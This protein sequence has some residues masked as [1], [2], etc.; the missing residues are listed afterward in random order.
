MAKEKSGKIG[1]GFFFYF[2]FFLL[3]II[4]AMLIIF[5]VMMFMPGKS[6]MGL[7][8]FA[9]KGTEKVEA[10]TDTKTQ[11]DFE[12]P[13]FNSVEISADYTNVTIQKNNDYNQNGIYIVNNSKGFVASKKARDFKYEVTLQDGVLKINVTEPTGFLYFSND[14]RVVF[15]IC[16]ENI[17][18]LA[19]K[20]VKIKTNGSVNIGGPVKTGYSYDLALG[21]LYIEGD[22]GSVTMS[23]HAPKTFADLSIK[24][25]SGGI[26]FNA[27]EVWARNM[28]LQ[29][30]S[31]NIY[32][33]KLD[34]ESFIILNTHNGKIEIGQISSF[35]SQCTDA[36]MTISRVNGSADFG[37]SAQT[38]ASS[39][40]NIG[41]ITGNLTALQAQNTDFKIG[42]VTGLTTVQTSTGSI[43]IEGALNSNS[44]LKTVS[45]S[46]DANVAAYVSN[47]TI[48]TQKGK[49]NINL[50]KAF[51]GV[52]IENQ[53]GESNLS[54]EK[55]G[56][57]TLNFAY[58]ESDNLNEFKFDNVNLNL[59]I[60]KTN[61]LVI[62]QGGSYINLKCNRQINF[63]WRESA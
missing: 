22:G 5:V 4:T 31:G 6:I 13:N 23:S 26:T 50:P 42:S 17:N 47:V 61:P 62:G 34:C 2:G 29:T 56:N 59:E 36:Y 57:Y 43:K 20:S 49:L 12:N 60:E 11:I 41:T 21:S 27:E 30:G 37:A 45:G 18:P 28:L 7:E 15:Q 10:T 54:L 25:Y 14:I 63:N 1:K 55:S 46:I 38:F 58:Y 48:S 9:G 24:T 39:V 51:D 3:L 35:S 44:S 40:I 52:N 53:T 16:N 19:E 33:N 32:A 8:Y